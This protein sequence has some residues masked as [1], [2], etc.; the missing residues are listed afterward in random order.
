M[1]AQ[2]KYL[3]LIL[4]LISISSGQPEEIAY[5]SPGLGVSWKLDGSYSVSAKISYGRV[6]GLTFKNITVEISRHILDNTINDLDVN[7][8]YQQGKRDPLIMRNT[9]V[10]I[11]SGSGYGISIPVQGKEYLPSLRISIFAGY[12]GFG[13]ASLQISDKISGEAGF[14]GV[15]PLANVISV[16]GEGDINTSA[17]AQ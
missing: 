16:L 1:R 13:K 3:V 11:L 10:N 5:I 12:I 7:V 6:I 2:V 15:F 17:A 9:G 14:E 8:E 4:L